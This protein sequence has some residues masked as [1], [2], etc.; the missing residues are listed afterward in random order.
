MELSKENGELLEQLWVPLVVAFV[1]Q[2][3]TREQ[4]HDVVNAVLRAIYE[5][6][7]EVP[8][9]MAAFDTKGQNVLAGLL[10]DQ[11]MTITGGMW[12]RNQTIGEA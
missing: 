2:G 5:A 7:P 10:C 8:A 12:Y 4:A 11:A 1:V 6:G 3:G 9:Y